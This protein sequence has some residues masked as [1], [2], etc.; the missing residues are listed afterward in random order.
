MATV[1]SWVQCGFV[2]V[3]YE[4]PISGS[5]ANI[6]QL[7]TKAFTDNGYAS[8][9]LQQSFLYRGEEIAFVSANDVPYAF[10]EKAV[11]RQRF[12]Q[13]W[14]SV[15]QMSIFFRYTVLIFY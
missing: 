1:C 7:F 10:S 14:I 2:S 12:L 6:G 9:G 13:H 15:S 3:S 5:S 8:E 4:D 11:S